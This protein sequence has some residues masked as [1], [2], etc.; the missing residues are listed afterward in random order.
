[1]ASLSQKVPSLTRIDLPH[2]LP[3]DLFHCFQDTGIFTY[4]F[5]RILREA[6]KADFIEG[7]YIEVTHQTGNTLLMPYIFRFVRTPVYIPD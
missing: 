1:M 4:I 7:T 6:A 2:H 3:Q 5:Q